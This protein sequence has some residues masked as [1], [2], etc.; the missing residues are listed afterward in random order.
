V[1]DR[2]GNHGDERAQRDATAP[3]GTRPFTSVTSRERCG[4]P[5][6]SYSQTCNYRTTSSRRSAAFC[7][8]GSSGSRRHTRGVVCD[9]WNCGTAHERAIPDMKI[10]I[11]MSGRLVADSGWPGDQA[12]WWRH[13]WG[14][15]E[16][17][18]R[19][20]D[21]PAFSQGGGRVSQLSRSIVKRLLP[22]PIVSAWTMPRARSN[23]PVPPVIAL[24]NEGGGLAVR[25]P[26]IIPC[27]VSWPPGRL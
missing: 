23:T 15:I 24:S 27:T 18:R 22:T 12:C 3:D 10:T 4:L 6:S 14:P 7:S 20:V 11:H 26:K 17:V 25:L 16:P 19:A 1:P 13:P 9:G 8:A 21:G 5:T 2:A